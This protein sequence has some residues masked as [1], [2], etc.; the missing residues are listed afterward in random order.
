MTQTSRRKNMQY[1]RGF[2]DRTPF[3]IILLYPCAELNNYIAKIKCIT[4]NTTNVT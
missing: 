2:I 3:A 4:R 1:I